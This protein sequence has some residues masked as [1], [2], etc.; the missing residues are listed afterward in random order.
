MVT[1]E[2]FG[3]A[4]IEL[5]SGADSAPLPFLETCL[6]TDFRQKPGLTRFLPAI[7]AEDGSSV[8]P[9]GWK[10]SGDIGAQARANAYLVTDPERESWAAGD[11]IQVLRK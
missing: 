11:R 4:A 3:R 1:L 10:G 6:S 8:A 2:I 7:L 9:A 5:L